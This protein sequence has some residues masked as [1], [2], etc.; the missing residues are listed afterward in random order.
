MPPPRRDL[1]QPRDYRER[2]RYRQQSP[3]RGRDEKDSSL[4]RRDRKERSSVD[5][6]VGRRR[7]L[8]RRS[9]SPRP[10]KSDRS[11]LQRNH[12]T[13]RPSYRDSRYNDD[14]RRRRYE[15]RGRYDSNRYERPRHDYRPDDFRG[16]RDVHRYDERIMR[17]SPVEIKRRIAGGRSRS[18]DRTERDNN[19]RRNE[20]MRQRRSP[21]RRRSASSSSSDDN[22]EEEVDLTEEQLMSKL[23]GVT[24][25]DS[26]KGKDHSTS[27]LSGANKKT[28]RRY[29]QYMN[30][31][32]GFNRPLS[33]VF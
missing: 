5:R 22:A 11:P 25:F 3:P 32:G 16:R 13:D 33:P 7:S 9:R 19:Y 12:R 10:G 18:M 17:R 29:R 28:K 2:G 1:E 27:D 21:S 8:H 20:G 15:E 4:E 30:R 24:D 31:R 6:Y 23:M 14:Q 26:T